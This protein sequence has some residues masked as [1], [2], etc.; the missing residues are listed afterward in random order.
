MIRRDL[1]AKGASKTAKAF[2]PDSEAHSRVVGPASEGGFFIEGGSHFT[3]RE[4]LVLDVDI[5]CADVHVEQHPHVD[6]PMIKTRQG[7]EATGG[8]ALGVGQHTVQEPRPTWVDGP[9][10]RHSKQAKIRS[11]LR[12]NGKLT[13][14]TFP[15]F[16]CRI[17]TLRRCHQ[18]AHE[19][20]K[21][22]FSIKV[23]RSRVYSQNAHFKIRKPVLQS[24]FGKG[25]NSRRV[26]TSPPNHETC[27]SIA[28][29]RSSWNVKSTTNTGTR[30]YGF[31]LLPRSLWSSARAGKGKG[32]RITLSMS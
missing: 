17:A 15:G 2:R 13:D 11:L 10:S 3:I 4:T 23:S 26:T 20:K 1:L 28:A 12:R 21:R 30:L 9:R 24:T 27:L 25:T 18:N 31:C 7:E 16:T 6:E 22:D 29:K 19:G 32:V 5:P 14:S 8:Q